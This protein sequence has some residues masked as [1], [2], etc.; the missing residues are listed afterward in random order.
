[1]NKSSQLK[2]GKCKVNGFHRDIVWTAKVI[3]QIILSVSLK[4]CAS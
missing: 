1:M 2:S 4:T 3:F